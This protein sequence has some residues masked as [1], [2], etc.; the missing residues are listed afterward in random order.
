MTGSAVKYNGNGHILHFVQ[1]TKQQHIKD[2]VLNIDFDKGRVGGNYGT[3]T[4]K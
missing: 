4:R 3:S 2:G 1:E